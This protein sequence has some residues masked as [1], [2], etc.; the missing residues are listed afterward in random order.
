MI[1]LNIDDFTHSLKQAI[2]L[3][4]WNDQISDS[5][6]TR[7][8]SIIHYSYQAT[9]S[10]KVHRNAIGIYHLDFTVDKYFIRVDFIHRAINKYILDDRYV[11]KIK[12]HSSKNAGS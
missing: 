7:L 6:L 8:S 12:N 1:K 3:I 10:Y 11:S 5:D 4:H 9:Y 2:E